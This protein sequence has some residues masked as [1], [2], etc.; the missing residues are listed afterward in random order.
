M[1]EQSRAKREELKEE[2]GLTAAQVERDQKRTEQAVK[3]QVERAYAEHKIAS[4]HLEDELKSAATEAEGQVIEAK[5]A[6]QEQAF[7]AN[8]LAIVESTMDS[9]VPEVVTREETKKEQKRANQTMDDARSHLRGFARTIPMFLM[10]YGDR[11]LRLS[12]FDD[13]TPDDVF[14]EIT[15]ITEDGVPAPARRPGGHRGGRH[16]HE[17]PGPVRRGRL[18]PGRPGVPGQEGSARRLLRRRAD[19]EHLRLY[20]AA[21]DVSGLHPG[22]RGQAH[23][24]Q[25]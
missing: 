16:R 4:K 1:T 14:E 10:A 22:V 25:P 23:G 18:R 9:I 17:D 12:S 20:P 21:E 11:G 15:G 7:K 5:K 8:I 6:E 19:R 3:D 24:R 13:Y 2:Y